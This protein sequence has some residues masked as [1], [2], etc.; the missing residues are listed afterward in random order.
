VSIAQKRREVLEKIAA[1]LQA[2]GISSRFAISGAGIG[3]LRIGKIKDI[4]SLF[5]HLTL[6][7][8]ADKLKRLS[9]TS[10]VISEVVICC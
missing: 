10:E 3:S 1:F 9:I 4:I 2:Y 6:V 5:S 8:K 7:V